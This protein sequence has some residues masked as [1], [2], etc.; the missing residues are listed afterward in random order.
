[1]ETHAP[2]RRRIIV[3]LAFALACV[4]LTIAAYVSFGGSFPFAPRGYRFE[5]PLPNAENL[6]QGSDVQMA[7]VKIGRIVNVVRNGNRAVAT[8][9]LNEQYAPIRSGATAIVR[10][11]TL[12]GEAYVELAAGPQS[13]P[14]VRDGGELAPS[15]ARPAVTLDQFLSSFG[16]TAREQMRQLFAGLSSALVGQGQALNDSLGYAAP[17]SANLGAV[18]DTLN[19]E[20]AQLQRLF[21]SSGTVLTALGQRRGDLRAAINAGD[22]VLATTAAR[23]QQLAATVRALPPF[24]DQLRSTANTITAASPDLDN[25]VGALLPIAPLL[26]PALRDIEAY[27][28]EFRALFHD[29]PA[30]IAAGKR[31]LPALTDILANLPSAF[32][33]LYPTSRQ[34]IPV[35]QLLAAYRGPALVTPIANTASLFN[36]TLVAPGGKIVHSANGSFYFSNETPVGWVKRLPTNRSNPYPTPTGLS[37]I[38]KQ[39]F[40]NSYDCR[41]VHNILY[42]PPLGTGVPP[43]VTQGPWDY[44]GVTAYYP[45]L[46]QAGP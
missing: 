22:E 1:M 38:Q 27:V 34:L 29:L 9:Q 41:N 3:S 6:V 21:A 32:R 10:T 39:G 20:T 18:F 19:V 14:P 12:L 35:M 11:K 24:L 43:C 46:Q 15:H 33:Y 36:G 4:L 25:A 8:V 44:R 13:A 40:L 17:V 37:E 30:T 31:G 45:R 26:P 28:P 16:P 23:N 42:L 7:G 5:L 2:P